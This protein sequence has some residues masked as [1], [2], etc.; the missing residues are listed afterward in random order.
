MDGTGQ[1][2]LKMAPL[3]AMGRR[4]CIIPPLPQVPHR[5]CKSNANIIP[6]DS[7]STLS[8]RRKL[9]GVQYDGNECYPVGSTGALVAAR[10][11]IIVTVTGT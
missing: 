7:V 2:S 11:P 9:L 10:T 1:G 8:P 4:L 5:E 3:E 6:S